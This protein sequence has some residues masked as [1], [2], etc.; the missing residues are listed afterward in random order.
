[1]DRSGLVEA[2]RQRTGTDGGLTPEDVGRVV[3]AVFGTV[4]AAGAIAEALR[5]GRT[6]SLDAFGSFH[7]RDGEPGLRPGKALIEFVNGQV[8]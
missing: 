8:G 1:M 4:D 2:V 7:H 3:D 6:V 5:E